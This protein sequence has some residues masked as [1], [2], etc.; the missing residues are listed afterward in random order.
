M[1]ETSKTRT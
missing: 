1:E